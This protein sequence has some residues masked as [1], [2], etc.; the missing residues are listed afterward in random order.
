MGVSF[1][2]DAFCRPGYK[3]TTTPYV[4]VDL[5]SKEPRQLQCN[6][7]NDITKALR[8]VKCIQLSL[9]NAIFTEPE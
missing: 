4:Y 9:C 5:E 1:S 2:F 6:I 3:E 7:R 8:N